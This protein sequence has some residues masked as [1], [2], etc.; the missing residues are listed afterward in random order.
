MIEANQRLRSGFALLDR[1]IE[2]LTHEDL[3]SAGCLGPGLAELQVIVD[4]G[5]INPGPNDSA[6]EGVSLHK[7][8]KSPRAQ[9]SPRVTRS[10]TAGLSLPFRPHISGVPSTPTPAQ[11]KPASAQMTTPDV[12]DY[13]LEE[14]MPSPLEHSLA[15]STL[16]SAPPTGSSV[17]SIPNDDSIYVDD[18]ERGMFIA[19]DEQTV[20]A[21]LVNLLQP[22]TWACG[23]SRGV[24]FDRQPFYLGPKANPLYQAR[25][26]GLLMIKD[27]IKGFMEVKPT[28]RN[29]DGVMVR[30]QESA[31][32]AAFIYDQG[33]KMTSPIG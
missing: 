30:I 27:D 10:M 15:S 6:E 13:H 18:L 2:T 22:I 19:G 21:S 26:D 32:M 28:L 17:A 5:A 23:L 9:Q 11:K 14:N 33:P 3:L 8:L 12:K 20:N 16:A 1:R 4:R 29:V 25:V 24:Y 7:I 31:E